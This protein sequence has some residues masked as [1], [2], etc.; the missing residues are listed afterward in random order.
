[1]SSLAKDSDCDGEVPIAVPPETLLRTVS[2]TVVLR[3][4]V[5]SQVHDVSSGSKLQPVPTV[6]HG[7]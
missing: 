1:M 7:V 4:A 3:A 6:L 2:V 5:A